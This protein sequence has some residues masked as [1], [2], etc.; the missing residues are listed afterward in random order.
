[1]MNVRY[2]ILTIF[3]FLAMVGA[4]CLTYGGKV[5]S[6]MS[7]GVDRIPTKIGCYPLLSTV[8][9]YEQRRG[10]R[11]VK[12]LGSM[13]KSDSHVYITP[14][15][16][17]GL[18]VTQESQ[19]LT[20][21]VS[22]ELAAYGFHLKEL[23][24][25]VLDV[26]ENGYD[27]DS[28]GK[29]FVIS[30]D[31]L[32]ELHDNYGVEALLMGEAFFMIDPASVHLE[33]EVTYARLKVVDIETLDVLAQVTMSYDADGADLNKAAQKMAREMAMMANLAVE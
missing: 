17:T 4:G 1:M 24:V 30:L 16:E 20:G 29:T 6:T 23:P 9:D 15:T 8:V 13:E 19:I 33:R 22:M 32:D 27:S 5:A 28:V 10:W 25:E 11:H 21:L 7:D 12:P 2:G 18:S 31:L 26:D 3:A 14:P